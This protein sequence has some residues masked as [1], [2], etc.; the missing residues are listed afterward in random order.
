[1]EVSALSECFLF[2]FLFQEEI[3]TAVD[4]VVM[5]TRSDDLDLPFS[6]RDS[7]ILVDQAQERTSA[8][9]NLSRSTISRV[10]LVDFY[11]LSQEQTLFLINH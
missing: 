10:P 8:L 2:Y 3:G 7:D 4:E 11:L 6:D 5:P 9:I 1:M